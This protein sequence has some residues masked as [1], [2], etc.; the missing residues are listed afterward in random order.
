MYFLM[1]PRNFTW[2]PVVTF[3]VRMKNKTLIYGLNAS[4]L[5]ISSMIKLLPA[6]RYGSSKQR[7]YNSIQV[8]CI[9][10][11]ESTWSFPFGPLFEY[12]PCIQ[13]VAPAACVWAACSVFPVNNT[14]PHRRYN[15]MFIL[16]WNARFSITGWLSRLPECDRQTSHLSAAELRVILNK[17]CSCTTEVWWF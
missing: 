13:S 11:M 2:L 10:Y 6:F 5:P 1:K 15:L 16:F 3:Q 17:P 9:F 4:A 12:K 7:V 14:Q 8:H